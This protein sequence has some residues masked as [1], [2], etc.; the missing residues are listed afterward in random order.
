[1]LWLVLACS[2]PVVSE[3]VVV[4]TAPQDCS[5]P[6]D[7]TR[8]LMRWHKEHCLYLIEC[9]EPDLDYYECVNYL[10]QANSAIYDGPD[11]GWCFDWCAA[12][13]AY[14]LWEDVECYASPDLTTYNEDEPAPFYICG[15]T[16]WP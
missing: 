2:Q 15:E 3:S 4:D 1:M 9:V 10:G 6:G 11:Q 16:Q 7:I 14:K 12:R 5:E 8:Y 13:E